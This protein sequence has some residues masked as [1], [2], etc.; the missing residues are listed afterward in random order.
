[1]QLVSSFMEVPEISQCHLLQIVSD[2][3]KNRLEKSASIE[4]WLTWEVL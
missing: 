2:E 4:E 1:M 3:M